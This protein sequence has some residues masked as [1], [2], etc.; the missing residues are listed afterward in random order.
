MRPLVLVL[1]T[2]ISAGTAMRVQ[3][4]AAPCAD[5]ASSSVKCL[6]P[7]AQ[8]GAA[9][10]AFEMNGHSAES[11]GNSRVSPQPSPQQL[12]DSAVGHAIAANPQRA[13]ENQ[14][15]YTIRVTRIARESVA[16]RS[17]QAATILLNR[18]EELE[19]MKQRMKPQ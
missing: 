14:L 11:G 10:G 9:D 18:L 1:A 19:D 6:R 15:D 17:P 7:A 12:A 5:T 4:Q 16:Q 8:D 3:G 13:G 2:A